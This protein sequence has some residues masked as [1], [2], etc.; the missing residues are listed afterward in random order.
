MFGLDE[1]QTVGLDAL[2]VEVVAFRADDDGEFGSVEYP[3]VSVV[4]VVWV[5]WLVV[6]F[7]TVFLMAGETLEQEDVMVERVFDTLFKQ[8]AVFVT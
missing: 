6:D 7:D 4:D 8:D 5:L 1:C 2:G 3:E